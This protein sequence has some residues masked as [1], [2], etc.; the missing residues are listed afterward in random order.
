MPLLELAICLLVT[1][2]EVGLPGEKRLGNYTPDF[3]YMFDGWLGR[4]EDKV[5]TSSNIMSGDRLRNA[6]RFQD[7]KALCDYQGEYKG[8]VGE[9]ALLFAEHRLA[10]IALNGRCR[11]RFGDSAVQDGFATE[12]SAWDVVNQLTTFGDRGQYGGSFPS[13]LEKR[14]VRV[15]LPKGAKAPY[16]GVF[17][18]TFASKSREE[19]RLRCLTSKTESVQP[20]IAKDKGLDL[21]SCAVLGVY[22]G[23]RF[24]QGDPDITGF[25]TVHVLFTRPDHMHS[26]LA[27]FPR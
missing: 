2:K 5:I 7:T 14:G 16:R 27:P 20:T 23:Q 22:T 4:S 11:L 13:A 10:G 17:V 19:V 15:W 9:A 21:G 18:V 24:W 25:S 26:F 6:R 1:Q 8:M 3:A 12:A